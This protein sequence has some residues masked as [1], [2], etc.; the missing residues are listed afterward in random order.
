MTDRTSLGQDRRRVWRRHSGAGA[1]PV[2]GGLHF[3]ERTG[4]RSSVVVSVGRPIDLEPFRAMANDDPVRM[5]TDRIQLALETLIL[6]LGEAERR[7]FVEGIEQL[8]A[9]EARAASPGS[10]SL[11][12]ARGIAECVEYYAQTDP[13]QLVY[14][15]KR[16]QRYQRRLE[17]LGIEDRAVRDAVAG[18]RGAERRWLS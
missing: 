18:L 5:L 2:A 4:F 14:G 9:D 3:T 6:H 10:H 12:V 16:I 17:A 7:S 13:A 1:R 15:L 11:D 8:Y